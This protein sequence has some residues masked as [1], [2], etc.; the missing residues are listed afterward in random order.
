MEDLLPPI[1]NPKWENH[2]IKTPLENTRRP[3]LEGLLGRN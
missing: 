1:P 3:D 2:E